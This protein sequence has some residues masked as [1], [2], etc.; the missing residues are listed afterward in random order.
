MTDGVERLSINLDQKFYKI[1]IYFERIP[2]EPTIDGWGI[3]FGI[4]LVGLSIVEI[5]KIK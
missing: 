2:G 1:E 4:A 5:T 3:T